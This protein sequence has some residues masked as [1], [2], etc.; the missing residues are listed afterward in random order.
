MM[1]MELVKKRRKRRMKMIKLVKSKIKMMIKRRK[2]K[3][4]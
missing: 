1:T 3:T 2:I 4:E